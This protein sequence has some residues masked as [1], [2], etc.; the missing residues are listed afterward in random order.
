MTTTSTKTTV[1]KTTVASS[2]ASSKEGGEEFQRALDGPKNPPTMPKGDPSDDRLS[3][4]LKETFPASDPVS[5]TGPD[6][7]T[8]PVGDAGKRKVTVDTT[9]QTESR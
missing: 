4:A 1:A 7:P 3:K 9:R 6:D 5:I 8:H 2:H